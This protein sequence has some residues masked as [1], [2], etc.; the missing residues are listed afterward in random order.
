MY[1][2]ILYNWPTN[3]ETIFHQSL[4]HIN[5][6]AVYIQLP[7]LNQMMNAVCHSFVITNNAVSQCYT[8]KDC[9]GHSFVYLKDGVD[10]RLVTMEML[11]EPHFRIKCK[12]CW[13]QLCLSCL[14]DEQCLWEAFL[15][16]HS[17]FVTI[18]VSRCL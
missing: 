18:Y 9:S 10:H 5:K 3:D 14:S 16:K 7:L 11:L 12:C 6:I 2:Q 15:L 8:N 13:P 4:C 17:L 1:E